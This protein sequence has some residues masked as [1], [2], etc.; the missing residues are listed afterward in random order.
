MTELG[1]A[2]ASPARPGQAEAAGTQEREAREEEGTREEGRTQ[3]GGLKPPLHKKEK[4]DPR[5]PI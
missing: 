5:G 3:E 2:P 1:E 4:R